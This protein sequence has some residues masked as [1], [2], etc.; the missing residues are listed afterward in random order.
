MTDAN[1]PRAHDISIEVLL[2]DD[3]EQWANYLADDLERQDGN[4]SVS[5]AL[6]ANEAMVALADGPVDVVVADYLMPEVD[7]LQLLERIRDERALLPFI[8]VTA[9]GSEEVASTAIE[10]GVTDYLV[11]NP[12]TDQTPLLAQR[13]RAAFEQFR[14]RRR[15]RESEAR[16]RTVAERSHDAIAIVQAGRLHYHN[17]RLC[18]LTGYDSAY[19]DGVDFVQ[20]LIHEADRGTVRE[21]LAGNKGPEGSLFEARLLTEREQVRDGEFAWATIDYEDDAAVLLTIRDVTRRK[22]R[23]ERIDRERRLNRGIFDALLGSAPR[24]EIEELVLQQFVDHGYELVWMGEPDGDGVAARARMGSDGY[25]SRIA[26][27]GIVDAPGEPAVIAARTGESRF[28]SDVQDLLESSWREGVEGI[29][30]R[31]VAAIPVAY[32]DV[33]YGVL[34]VYH[35]DPERFDE[36]ERELL[37]EAARTLGFAIHH[38]ETRRALGSD[39]PVRVEVTLAGEGYP[40]SG[41]LG[42]AGFDTGRVQATIHGTHVGTAGRTVQYVSV[43]GASAEEVAAALRSGDHVTDVLVLDRDDER[44]QVTLEERPVEG[45]L[46]DRGARVDRT[47]VTPDGATVTFSLGDRTGVSDVI[48]AIEDHYGPASVESITDAE[49]QPQTTT[50]QV[51][52]E[53]LTDKQIA[54]L[55]A[56]RHHG[57]FDQPRGSSASAIADA[58]DV[59]HSTFLQHL[60]AAQRKLVDQL[61]EGSNVR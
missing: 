42:G 43:S 16:Y 19:L 57:Y 35:R 51:N 60:R 52:L 15:L 41:I 13:I 46:T 26:T 34:A 7:G 40:L 9:G 1:D 33:R 20:S 58:L 37:I 44:V 2:V 4:L 18:D 54:A 24:P 45:L 12:N 27:D 28:I 59:S 39:A 23:E 56:A 38:V 11:K 5:V 50:H 21:R 47:I 17:Q 48:G 49:P 6:S 8:L 14:L 29:G 55:E 10:A 32:D 61:F 30:V 25:L 36:T 3:N 31:S 53:A 22:R